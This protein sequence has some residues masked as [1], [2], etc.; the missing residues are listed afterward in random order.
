VDD[1]KKLFVI[2]GVMAL[3]FGTLGISEAELID[4][5]GL[6]LS[7][8][9]SIPTLGIVSFYNAVAAQGNSGFYGGGPMAAIGNT[10]ISPVEVYVRPIDISFLNPV[11]NLQFDVA[12]ID[13]NGS[14]AIERLTATAYD[15]SNNLLASIAID[16]SMIGTGD[17]VVTHFDFGALSGIS[18]LGLRL[19]NIGTG[20]VYGGIFW[21]MDNLQFDA[22]NPIP[23]PATML[24]LGSGLIGLTGF[25]KKKKCRR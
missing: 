25:R 23:E 21:G 10:Y 19:D 15:S 6:G 1:M 24:L 7:P 4:F 13:A 18:F 11:A 3:V 5:D 14:V 2:L 8:G 9:D 20:P 22:A 12:D 17:G 16:A